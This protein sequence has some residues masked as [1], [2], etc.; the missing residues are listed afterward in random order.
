[1]NLAPAGQISLVRC[2][3][4][5]DRASQVHKGVVFKDVGGKG[6]IDGTK[7]AGHGH[8]AILV[9]SEIDDTIVGNDVE[10]IQERKGGS[11]WLIPTREDRATDGRDRKMTAPRDDFA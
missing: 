9:K 4:N 2:P 11:A 8:E 1:M 7:N 3:T 10:A 5:H 6:W